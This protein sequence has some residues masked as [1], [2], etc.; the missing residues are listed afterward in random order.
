MMKVVS[1]NVPTV[2]SG[3]VQRVRDKENFKLFIK[4]ST[5]L[6]SQR[7]LFTSFLKLETEKTLKLSKS[8]K[9]I[10]VFYVSSLKKE[11][12]HFSTSG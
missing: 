8:R 9:F 4:V 5:L 10:G 1:S 2:I 7:S 6:R 11:E 12:E 3:D